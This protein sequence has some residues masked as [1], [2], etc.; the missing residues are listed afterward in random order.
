MD[1]DN[2][3][4]FRKIKLLNQELSQQRSAR[5]GESAYVAQQAA[6]YTTMLQ[7]DADSERAQKLFDAENAE[8]TAEI[9]KLAAELRQQQQETEDADLAETLTDA[10]YQAHQDEQQ[11]TMAALQVKVIAQQEKCIVLNKQMD[12][13]N[14]RQVSDRWRHDETVAANEALKTSRQHRRNRMEQQLDEMFR[15]MEPLFNIDAVSIAAKVI[16]T[17]DGLIEGQPLIIDRLLELKEQVRSTQHLWNVH[18]LGQQILEQGLETD[19]AENLLEILDKKGNL[20]A[21]LQTITL[22]A[23]SAN[24][25]SPL[26]TMPKS[27]SAPVCRILSGAEAWDWDVSRLQKATEGRELSS[28]SLWVFHRLGLEAEFDL[29]ETKLVRFLRRIESG[30]GS[31]PYHN[32]T[33][34][35][36]VVQMAY[37]LLTAGGMYP[38]HIGWTGVLSFILAAI[39]HEYDHTGFT[40]DFL[41]ES[42]HP[43]AVTFNDSS[44]QEN[45]HVSSAW[46]L[47]N[48]PAYDFMCRLPASTRASIRKHVVP[49]VLATDMKLHYECMSK[50]SLVCAST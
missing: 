25:V 5:E 33:H 19:V 36:N 7:D 15:M 14:V 31:H 1:A 39:I 6:D 49:L 13:E 4:Q 23:L 22:A 28:V 34:A 50:Q 47:L 21:P 37:K 26:A 16:S 8:N 11:R 18:N 3:A 12:V 10:A 2:L 38:A 42:A 48:E 29:D 40:N 20:M 9:D 46:K 41:V 24:S 30:Y 27:L 32:C 44:P 35:A 45:H 17:I 43:Y